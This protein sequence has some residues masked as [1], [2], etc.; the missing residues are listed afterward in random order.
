MIRES[1]GEGG[2]EEG[3]RRKKRRE[4]RRGKRKRVKEKERK[5]EGERYA[6]D[7][8]TLILFNPI[9]I[10]SFQMINLDDNFKID[11]RLV[12]DFENLF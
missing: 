12:L 9:F 6:C 10:F 1:E 7:E 5:E 2:R 3:G 4:E 11:F 8:E